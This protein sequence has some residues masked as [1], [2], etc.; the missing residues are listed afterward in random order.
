MYGVGGTYIMNVGINKNRIIITDQNS[1]TFNS[2][3]FSGYHK[4]DFRKG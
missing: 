4:F 2:E 3:N 1:E